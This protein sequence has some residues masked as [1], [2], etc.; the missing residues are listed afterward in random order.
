LQI[1]WLR[2]AWR[3]GYP[4]SGED[5]K[6]DPVKTA[7]PGGSFTESYRQLG[8]YA[9]RIL[10]GE[11]PADLPVQ[12]PTK[13]ELAINL[14]TAKALGLTV[15][16]GI[17]RHRWRGHRMMKRRECITFLGGAAAAWPVV[18]H[19]QQPVVPVVGF[20]YSGS[21]NAES[22]LTTGF[23]QGLSE[24]GYVEGRNVRVEYHYV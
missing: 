2:I 11:K 5:W 14:Q 23:R 6:S 3:I 16:A 12:A 9:G 7:Q 19:A 22:L 17:A 8:I 15:P 10:K 24:A 18:A 21:A 4:L 13:Y 1:N 20:L